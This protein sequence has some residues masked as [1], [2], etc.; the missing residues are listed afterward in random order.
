M[1]NQWSRKHPKEAGRYTK[2]WVLAHP[3]QH[4]ASRAKAKRRRKLTAL[5]I[6]EVDIALCGD[7]C[8]ICQRQV[9]LVIDHNHETGKF[10]GMLCT[11]CNVY[12]GVVR[13]DPT[14]FQRG[15]EYL[16]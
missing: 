7:K 11:A 13:D 12:L 2:K 5:G 16:T 1:G 4:A 15:V 14:A 10:R 6:T 9:K 3:E 8:Y